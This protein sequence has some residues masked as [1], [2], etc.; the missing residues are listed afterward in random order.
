MARMIEIK[1][2][3][4][5]NKICSAEYTSFVTFVVIHII[6][7]ESLNVVQSSRYVDI[8]FAFQHEEYN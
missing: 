8:P 2:C 3:K 1:S 4:K 6:K 5:N 7:Q